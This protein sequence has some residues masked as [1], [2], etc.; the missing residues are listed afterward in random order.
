MHIKF[1]DKSRACMHGIVPSGIVSELG[2]EYCFFRHEVAR[3]SMSVTLDE[4]GDCC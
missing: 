1:V 4:V 2:F 3:C